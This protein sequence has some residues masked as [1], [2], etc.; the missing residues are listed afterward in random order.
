V[1]KCII[2]YKEI[3]KKEW[4]RV[5]IPV[6]S[7]K[8]DKDRKSSRPK[9]LSVISIQYWINK[10]LTDHEAKEK[11][12]YLQRLRSPRCIEYWLKK[13]FSELIAKEKV[14]LYQQKNGKQNE[15]K[16]SKEERAKRSPFCVEYWLEKG[17]SLTESKKIIKQN[18]S[19]ISLPTLIKKY[20][21]KL[22]TE[23]YNQI[24]AHRKN[25][26]TFNGYIQKYGIEEGSRIW[27][28]K[29]KNRPNSKKANNFFKQLIE[30]VPKE[31]KIYAATSELGEYGIN[32]N[33]IYYFYDFVIPSLKICVE[34]NGDYWHC[35]P[36]KYL[37]E[38]VHKQSRLTAKEIQQKDN[39]KHEAIK[40]LRGFDVYVVWESE[41]KVMLP[42]IQNIIVNRIK[43]NEKCQL[44]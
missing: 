42:V 18:S 21:E 28:Q 33:G 5:S 15:I 20:G 44:I 32:S 35:N 37:P 4:Y 2:C 26:Y 22:G 27:Q 23:K 40:K 16:Y 1:Y 9:R 41:Y 25:F 31:Y 13:G 6:C 34:F 17:F 7:E 39:I 36:S 38:F 11:V 24:C 12:S 3:R 19:T 10:G 43:E 30:V 8:C 29:F 14:F